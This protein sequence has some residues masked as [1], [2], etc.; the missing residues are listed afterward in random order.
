MDEYGKT[1]IFLESVSV[2]GYESVIMFYLLQEGCNDTHADFNGIYGEF[3]H[4]SLEPILGGENSLSNATQSFPCDYQA[5]LR[6]HHF[7]YAPEI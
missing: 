6:N 4:I 3:H 1:S 5:F 2:W 7:V